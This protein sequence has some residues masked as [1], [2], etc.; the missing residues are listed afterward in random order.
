MQQEVMMHPRRARGLVKLAVLSGVVLV[1]AA[2]SSGT[3]T[4]SPP[5]PAR[6]TQ[7]PGARSR[8]RDAYTGVVSGVT[9]TA[10]TIRTKTS[11]TTVALA[12]ATKYREGG[13]SVTESALSAGEHVRVRLAKHA[14]TPTAAV[15]VILPP[16]VTGVVSGLGSG[17]FTLTSANGTVHAVTTSSSTTY[18]SAGRARMVAGVTD[19][20]HV[21]VSGQILP[22]GTVS[23]SS[24][25][26][27]GTKKS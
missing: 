24:V 8:A 20:E 21:R 16:S 26:V 5:V 10:M 1:A 19:G 7:A 14:K 13:N 15:V 23:A 27:L 9:P 12:S 11:S 22:N 3:K 2:C 17:G 18:R 6:A 25:V 4:S